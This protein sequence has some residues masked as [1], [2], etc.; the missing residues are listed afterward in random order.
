MDSETRMNFPRER[1]RCGSLDILKLILAYGIAFFHLG[2]P[3][4][5]GPTVS[6]QVF[7]LISGF[8]LGRKFYAR[9]YP[10]PEGYTAWNYT[11]DHIKALYPH[12]LFSLAAM[13][14]YDLARDL[15]Y[16]IP[17][18]SLAKLS[19]IAQDLYYQIPDLFLLQS[20]Y[21]FHESLNYPLWQLSALLIAGYFLY[22]LLCRDEKLA[23]RI[24]FPGGIL[25]ILSLLNTGVDLWANY[26]PLYIPLLRAVCPMCVGV[27][28]Y[29]FTGTA[30]YQKLTRYRTA[31]NIASVLCLVSLFVYADRAGIFLITVPILILVCWNEDSWLSR[32]SDRPWS[33]FAGKFSYAVYLNHAL[34]ARFTIAVLIT[35]AQKIGLLTESWQQGLT[36]F[37]LLTAYS[38]VTVTLV[39]RW[40]KRRGIPASCMAGH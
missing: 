5:P 4:P 3:I 22:A 28:T 30:L 18:P 14:L 7:F 2:Q 12:Y 13:F 34:I 15:L 6:V 10:D 32:L 11:L 40:R 17:E 19:D 31:G 29:C 27:L 20:S 36:F 1:R 21:R 16:L 35:N 37:L 25:M 39:D 24:L 38:T 9:S 33:R 8:F 23:R 26:G